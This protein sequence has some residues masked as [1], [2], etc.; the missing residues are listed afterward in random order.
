LVATNEITGTAWCIF[1][2]W[3]WDI[4]V[5]IVEGNGLLVN[6]DFCFSFVSLDVAVNLF[7]ET[8][9]VVYVT[10]SFEFGE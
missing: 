5:L 2:G 1:A 4:L 3:Q 8:V 9:I 10:A 6:G 7:P